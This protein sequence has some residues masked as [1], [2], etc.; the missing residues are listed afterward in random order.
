MTMGGLSG[1]WGMMLAS[2][3]IDLI[4]AAIVVAGLPGTAAWAIGLL[5]GLNLM[6]GGATLIGMALAARNT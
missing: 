3:I 4:L 6:F 5:V 1:Q 2:G